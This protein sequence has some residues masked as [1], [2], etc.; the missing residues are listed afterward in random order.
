MAWEW[1]APV[2]TGAV[3][4]AGISGT[5]LGGALLRRSQEKADRVRV[6]RERTEAL[7]VSVLAD[8]RALLARSRPG[9]TIVGD[10]QTPMTT[11]EMLQRF[12]RLAI[13]ANPQVV[14]TNDEFVRECRE[15]SHWATLSTWRVR[16][17]LRD[18]FPNDPTY[19]FPDEAEG[20]GHEE[21]ATRA[22]EHWQRASDLCDRLVEEIRREVH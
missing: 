21:M 7:Y 17:G 19:I 11:D 12:A 14:A 1:V 10:P 6:K 22:K 9:V 13:F 15:A 4:I 8:A 16:E 3:G 18:T 20:L 5:L 2:V